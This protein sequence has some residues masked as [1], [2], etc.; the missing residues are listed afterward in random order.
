MGTDYEKAAELLIA[1]VDQ[2]RAENKQLKEILETEKFNE[3]VQSRLKKVEKT[4]TAKADEYARGDRLS[5]FKQIAHLLHITPEK[6]LIGLVSKHI[7]ALVDFVNDIDNNVIQP[8]LK[9]D[10]KI[11]DINAYMILL[12]AIVQE[13]LKVKDKT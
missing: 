10:E 11:G 7:V 6:A 8:Y 3:I 12:D 4:L 2:L 5:N 9:W 13:R 1:K